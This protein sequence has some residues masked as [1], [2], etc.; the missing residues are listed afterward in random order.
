[1]KE[2]IR[3]ST[4]QGEGSI[5]HW[6]QRFS[7]TTMAVRMWEMTRSQQ[8]CQHNWPVQGP[9]QSLKRVSIPFIKPHICMFMSRWLPGQQMALL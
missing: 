2:D 8:P 3:E 7:W 9:V 6:A 4:T 1:M 5:R